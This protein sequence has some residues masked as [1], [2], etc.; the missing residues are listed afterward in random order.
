MKKVEEYLA[1]CI[2]YQQVKVEPQHPAKL[3]QSLPIPKWKWKW[4]LLVLHKWKWKLLL[5]FNFSTTY[6]P[7]SERQT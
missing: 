4:K 3:L 5:Q 6:H 1:Q 2:E 7:Q